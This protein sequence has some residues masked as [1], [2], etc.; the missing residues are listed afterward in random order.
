MDDQIGRLLNV[1]H[2]EGQL[3][4]TIVLFM[5]DNGP[6]DAVNNLEMLVWENLE[7]K[8]IHSEDWNLRNPNK[9]VGRKGEVWDNGIKIN[10]NLKKEI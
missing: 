6:V 3:E 2:E 5:S 4:N 1:L 7:N 9:L 8:N 10:R